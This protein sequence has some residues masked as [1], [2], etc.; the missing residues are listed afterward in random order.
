M[1]CHQQ[2]DWKKFF[3]VGNVMSLE[4]LMRYMI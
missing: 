2:N 3:V 1:N 4:I